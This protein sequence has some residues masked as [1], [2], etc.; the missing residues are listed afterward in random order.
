[1]KLAIRQIE[2]VVSLESMLNDRL[3]QLLVKPLHIVDVVEVDS[4]DETVRGSG[5]YGSTG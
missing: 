4:L 3:C 1:M 2:N 5:G